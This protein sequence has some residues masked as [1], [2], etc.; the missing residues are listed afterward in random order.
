MDKKSKETIILFLETGEKWTKPTSIPECT[1]TH[2]CGSKDMASFRI[3][4]LSG[5]LNGAIPGFSSYG[6]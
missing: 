5:S 6:S 2:R 1:F 4:W 3:I